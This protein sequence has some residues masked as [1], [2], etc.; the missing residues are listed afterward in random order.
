M[1]APTLEFKSDH[2]FEKGHIMPEICR[3]DDLLKSL[4]V[5]PHEMKWEN[6]IY[7]R[8]GI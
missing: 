7:N 5:S 6:K 3:I 2:V 8:T 4:H 1:A